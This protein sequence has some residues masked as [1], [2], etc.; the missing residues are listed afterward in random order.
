MDKICIINGPNLHKIGERQVE[1]YGKRSFD[2]FLVELRALFPDLIIEYRQSHHE[3]ELIQWLH[4]SHSYKGIVLNAG[5]YTHTSVA[6]A[7]AVACAHCPVVEVHLSNIYARE[8]FR[9][10]SMIA[11]YSTGQITG[12]GLEGYRLAVIYLVSINK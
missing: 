11:A 5:G 3:G 9:R 6:L 4:D 8:P 2:E 1:I 12:L 10:Q 7:D